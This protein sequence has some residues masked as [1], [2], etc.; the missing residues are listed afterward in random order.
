MRFVTQQGL[1]RC[2]KVLGQA[3]ADLPSPSSE[4]G[5]KEYAR[6]SDLLRRTIHLVS[7]EMERVQDS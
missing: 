6:L 4:A 3:L 1:R 2:V 7:D 5:V